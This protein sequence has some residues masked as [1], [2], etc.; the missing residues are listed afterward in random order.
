MP[1]I[2]KLPY[3]QKDEF[4]NY[5]AT[6]MGLGR[7]G[8]G[9]GAARFLAEQG[10][11]VTVTDMKS[12]EE[13][14]ESMAALD[15]LGIRFVLGHH[16]MEDFTSAHMV[17]VSPAVPRA[18][19]YVMAARKAGAR[20]NSEIGLFFE[21]CPGKIVGITGSNGKS[22]T[23]SLLDAI[24]SRS[25][26]RHFTGGN[27]GVSLLQKLP[28]MDHHDIVVLE[29]SS[30]QL[31]WLDELGLSPEIACLLN[32]MP[33]H[34]DRHGSFE[35]YR[36]AKSA[37]FS[38]QRTGDKC[39]IVRDDPEARSLSHTARGKIVWVSA[40]E[41][42]TGV[43][44]EDGVVM[45][46]GWKKAEPL[47][48]ASILRIPGKHNIINSMAASACALELGID[49]E[50]IA[51]GVASFSGI[52]HRLEWVAEKND[53]SF[54]NDSKATTPE[55]AAAGIEAFDCPVL[56]ILGGYDK[57]VAFDGIAERLAGKLPWAAL[58]GQTA[59]LIASAFQA[60]GISCD[61]FESLEEA[62]KACASRAT[63]N[64]AVLLSPGCASYDMFPNYE[65]RG[66]AFRKLVEDVPNA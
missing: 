12:E 47:Y 63:E 26:K 6:V 20:M 36:T 35:N 53:I 16:D 60:H 50:T 8:G 58:I 44:L 21:R 1:P 4:R 22:T 24:L 10:A 18:S 57:Q 42:V 13:L 46:S 5:R 48:E 31:E 51:E 45:N 28:D 41:K 43:M 19:E 39:I 30:F 27:I 2:F 34:I 65:A 64:S 62:F 17:V 54:Y 49:S 38:Y 66:A 32:I 7:F 11:Q 55:A 52:P 29:L 15:G 59:P 33:N 14:A 37:I 3:D 9:I 23:V 61:R 25:G 40:R 56:P